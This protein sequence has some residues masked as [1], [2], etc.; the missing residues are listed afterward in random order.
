LLHPAN[1]ATNTATSTA[2]SDNRPRRDHPCHPTEAMASSPS[3][4]SIS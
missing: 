1:T 4:H 2:T 3:Q